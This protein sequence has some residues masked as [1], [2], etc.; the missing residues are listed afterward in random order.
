[1]P[2]KMRIKNGIRLGSICIAGACYL[3]DFS[4]FDHD[5]DYGFEYIFIKNRRG[6]IFEKSGCS[7]TLS[8]I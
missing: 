4:A 2:K 7:V 3:A 6:E 5:C 8:G 1:M